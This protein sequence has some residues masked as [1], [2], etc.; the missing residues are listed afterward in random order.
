MVIVIALFGIF[1]L[2]YFVIPARSTFK[3]Q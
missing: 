2:F 3:L 1:I